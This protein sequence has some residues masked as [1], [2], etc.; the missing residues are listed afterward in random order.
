[1]RISYDRGCQCAREMVTPHLLVT[2]PSSPAK[3]WKDSG[4]LKMAA[5]KAAISTLTFNPQAEE[6]LAGRS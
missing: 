4:T 1:M 5:R 2:F 3:A 6:V